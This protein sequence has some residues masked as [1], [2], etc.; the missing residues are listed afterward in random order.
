MVE[1]IIISNPQKFEKL[2]KEFIEKGKDKVH[3]LA[4]FDRTLTKCFV[5][6]EKV[7]SIIA[8]LRKEEFL[9][10]EY[11]QRTYDLFDQYHPIEIDPNIPFEEKKA[12]MDEWWRLHNAELIKHGLNKEHLEQV[13][14]SSKIQFRQGAL[15]F[16]DILKQKISLYLNFRNH[17]LTYIRTTISGDRL[18]SS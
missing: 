4:D 9:N 7:T 2:K 18:D 13:I 14:K 10:P 6:G 16:I 15:E 3:V 5:N 11:S 8:I 1:N 12:K 17:F